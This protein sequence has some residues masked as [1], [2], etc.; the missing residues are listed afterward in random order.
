M[1][2]TEFYIVANSF[3][4]PWFSD[5]DSAFVKAWS[6][7]G[8]LRKFAASYTHP[9]GLYCANCYRDANAEAKGEQPLA[10]WHSNHLAGLL[11]VT[12]GTGGYS[13][14]GRGPGDFDVDG[15]AVRIK[16]PKGGKVVRRALLE[17][18]K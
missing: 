11:R 12:K 1:S 16:N 8:A 7:G 6:P 14:F 2:M 18:A 17:R 13:Y 10:E 9:A 5:Q 3:A 4:A 15:K